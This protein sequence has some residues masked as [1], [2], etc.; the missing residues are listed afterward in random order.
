[1][2]DITNWTVDELL[3]VEYECSLCTGLL[4]AKYH[5]VHSTHPICMGAAQEEITRR[6]R[7]Y[8]GMVGNENSTVPRPA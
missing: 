8:D 3:K 7:L 1:M 6:A 2:K 5:Y 4:S